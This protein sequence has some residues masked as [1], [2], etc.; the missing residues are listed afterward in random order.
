MNLSAVAYASA[1][2]RRH[3]RLVCV[4]RGGDGEGGGA[5]YRA[6]GVAFG[7]TLAACF[8][9]AFAATAAIA[10]AATAASLSDA[11]NPS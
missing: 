7:A 1:T 2:L 5:H 3:Q 10:A 6:G 8:G 11:A 9:A 4:G